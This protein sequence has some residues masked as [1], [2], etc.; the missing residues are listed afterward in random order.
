MLQWIRALL[1]WVWGLFASV[2]GVRHASDLYE[3]RNSRRTCT[4]NIRKEPALEAEIVG[5]LAPGDRFQS[6]S[7]RRGWLRVEFNGMS[8][9]GTVTHGW[10]LQDIGGDRFLFPVVATDTGAIQRVWS[11][12]RLIYCDTGDV[13]NTAM[14]HHTQDSEDADSDNSNSPSF[15]LQYARA[16]QLQL[17][18]KKEE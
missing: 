5:K 9:T 7:S 6:R 18:G 10:A 3:Y 11:S 2:F 16:R 1:A 4:H 14:G 13:G 12:I 8:G 17:G 15:L